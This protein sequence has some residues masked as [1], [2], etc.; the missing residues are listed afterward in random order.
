MRRHGQVFSN[1]TVANMPEDSRPATPADQARPRIVRFTE[2]LEQAVHDAQHERVGDADFWDDD[3][4]HVPVRGYVALTKEQ[5]RSSKDGLAQALFS[6]GFLGRVKLLRPH[7]GEF[8]GQIA[9][10]QESTGGE[11][12]TPLDSVLGDPQVGQILAI[13][14]SMSSDQLS[15]KQISHALQELRRVDY[16]AFILVESM[17]GVWQERLLRLTRSQGLI[18]LHSYG[19]SL[20]ELSQ[21]TEFRELSSELSRL[22]SDHRPLATAIDAAALASLIFMNRE[23]VEGSGRV[24]PRF[25]T[26]SESLKRM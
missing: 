8:L 1:Q 4:L 21:T 25:F 3:S 24:F 7:R 2:I 14:R 10:W 13:T 20:A 26:S 22:R 18:D 12:P 11:P 19:R 15:E 16:R 17:A 23:S 9:T 6:A 5:H